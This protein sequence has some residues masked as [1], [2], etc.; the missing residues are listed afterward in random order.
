[1]LTFDF[2]AV[3][4]VLMGRTPH[5]NGHESSHDW[6][7]AAAALESVG[8]DV[9][10]E[11]AYPTLSGGEQQRVQLARVLAQIWDK[12]ST[13]E[14]YL[15]LDEPTTSLDIAHQHSTLRLARRFTNEGTAVL[16][17]LH[18]LNLAAQYADKIVMLKNGR[19][20]FAGSPNETIT[21]DGVQQVFD[22]AVQVMHHPKYGFPL[23]LPVS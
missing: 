15:L 18:D 14:R 23:V 5:N 8:L 16:A 11:R 10:A 2:S 9:I 22:M 1:M 19:T 12:P 20:I 17:V 7:I 3:E 6:K 21:A 13:G 4:V